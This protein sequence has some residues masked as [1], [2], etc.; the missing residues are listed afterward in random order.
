MA[1]QGASL[2]LPAS[3]N[4]REVITFQIGN[5]SNF[6][7]SHFWNLQESLFKD[8]SSKKNSCSEV[9][10]DILHRHGLNFDTGRRSYTPRVIAFDLRE[11]VKSFPRA[12]ETSTDDTDDGINWDGNVEKYHRGIENSNCATNSCP[13]TAN[14]VNN[15]FWTDL[16]LPCFHNKSL[17]TIDLL[18]S[19]T[20]EGFDHF[21]CGEMLFRSRKFYDG[22]EDRLHFFAEECDRLQGFQVR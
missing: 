13:S 8:A 5:Y 11:N 9:L 1:D 14:D 6:V 4:E 16:T 7:G 12:D 15:L 17:Q 21:G 3:K 2:D 22:F 19:E 20:S 10:H 18:H